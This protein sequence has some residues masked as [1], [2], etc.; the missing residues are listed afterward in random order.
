MLALRVWHVCA[1]LPCPFGWDQPA[2]SRRLEYL[3][4]AQTHVPLTLL[5]RNVQERTDDLAQALRASLEELANLRQQARAVAAQLG[6]E[7][8]AVQGKQGAHDGLTEARRAIMGVL[9]RSGPSW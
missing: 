2:W 4:V 6:A 5:S 9:A 3:G 8:L 1:Q 7:G